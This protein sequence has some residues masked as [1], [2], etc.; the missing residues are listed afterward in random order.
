MAETIP[1]GRVD[2]SV[3]GMTCNAC[4]ARLETALNR[5]SGVES[6]SVSLPIERA[7]VRF[8]SN[9]VGV[10]DIAGVVRRAGFEVACDDRIFK[11]DG[12]TCS[13]CVQR[14]E[15][16]LRDM[17][18]VVSA[19]V[20]LATNQALV[21]HYSY[22]VGPDDLK[23]SVARA[24]YTLRV[25]P[26]DAIE[27]AH[28][29]EREARERRTLFLSTA[30][31]LPLV[32]QMIFQF[33]GY[34][35]IHLMPAAE[36]VLAT[37]VQVLIAAPFYR[38]AYN[39]LR[40]RSAN[41][42][43]LVV[44]GTTSA[45]VYSWYLMVSLGEA[46]EG[47]L[48]FETSTVIITLVLFG[49]YLE[50]RAKRSTTKALRGLLQLRPTVAAV[51]TDDDEVVERSVSNLAVGDLLVCS[52][53]TRIAADG[54]IE[55]GAAHVDESLVTGESVPVRKSVGDEVV[56]GSFNLDGRI[57]VRVD[58]VGSDATIERVVRSVESA[59]LGKVDV[60]RLV[61]RVSQYFVPSV[62]SIA[63]LTFLVWVGISGSLE[64]ALINAVSVLV[65]ACPC[66]LGLATP[67]AI[68]TGTGAA[69]RAG[70]LIRDLSALETAHRIEHVAFDK[71]GTVT[72]GTHVL[73]HIQTMGNYSEN[74]ILQLAGSVQQASEHPIGHAIAEAARFRDLG[75]EP[76]EDFV[77]TVSEGVEGRLSG[78]HVVVG[79]SRMM[80]ARGHDVS[81]EHD[82]DGIES[83]V[84]V[85]SEVVGRIVV[86]DSVR[87][88]SESAIREIQRDGMA[89]SLLSG[90]TT[91][92]TKAIG[93]ELGI[94]DARGG[95]SPQ[96]K[97]DAIRALRDG[98]RIVAM[99][100]DGL[101][102]A[103]V[104]AGADVGIALS[105]GTDIAVDV[106]GITLMRPDPRLVH[107]A[108]EAS[109]RTVRKIRQN[110]FWAFIYNLVALPLAA[111]G[112]LTPIIAAAAMALSSVSVVL[113][114]TLIGR[115]RP[116]LSGPP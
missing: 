17:P 76:V 26:G 105:S 92:R 93:A 63:V 64:A 51:R 112:Y 22:A 99:V 14:V 75:L 70:V 45:Y 48:Y 103:P 98:D 6:A 3:K 95:L 82:F 43:V 27:D 21:Q 72:T 84:L 10:E 77:A 37:P 113:N 109:R 74:E 100:G 89:V 32:L 94:D 7:V 9:R 58:A 86:G 67:T 41:M 65:I 57:E 80:R 49:K 83:W 30:F 36:A 33:F 54:T 114:S 23:K 68:I 90:D 102:D 38:A 101:N 85:D 20:N 15:Q 78:H 19:S 25:P 29:R 47:E 79:S 16:A 115:W 97:L 116:Q 28:A 81:N 66:A 50:S 73:N 110:L 4:V 108:I 12:M 35:D 34:Y 55:V 44:L 69:A 60:Q 111:L 62:V 91:E 42:D 87:P 39:A 88:Q 8:E 2:L 40:S 11:V 31:T 18:G 106:A 1:I 56:E 61:D 13:A 46:A 52:P 104:L 107:T 96:A 59:Q 24:G 5:Q 53:G 71:T